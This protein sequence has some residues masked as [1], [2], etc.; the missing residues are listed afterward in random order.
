[1]LQVALEAERD[2]MRCIGIIEAGDR[3]RPRWWNGYEPQV[4][5]TETRLLELAMRRRPTPSTPFPSRVAHWIASRTPD[6]AALVRGV[7]THPAIA[8]S[9]DGHCGRAGRE[10]VTITAITRTDS[11]RRNLP[12]QH[13][14]TQTRS[15][16]KLLAY[17]QNRTWLC[18]KT[19]T[20]MGA[21]P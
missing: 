11:Q 4:L 5:P 8:E 7:Y 18:G 12:M 20:S 1:M 3:A 10:P 16:R 19:A 2:R 21:L 15:R 13:S 17:I 6:L 9:V 14:N